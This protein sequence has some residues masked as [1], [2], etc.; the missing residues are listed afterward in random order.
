MRN[1]VALRGTTPERDTPGLADR[2]TGPWRLSITTCGTNPK[3]APTSR[4]ARSRPRRFGRRTSGG[5]L[6][7]ACVSDFWLGAASREPSDAAMCGRRELQRRHV[8][9]LLRRNPGLN[10]V[11]VRDA[12][13][14][15]ADDPAVLEWAAGQGR[16]VITHD[17][18]TLTKH[19]F[20]R[21]AAGHSMPGVFEV[22]SVAGIGQAIDDSSCSPN[23]A[24]RAS[25]GPTGGS[26]S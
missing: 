6:P 5:S 26:T 14:S 16:V 10:I 20:N 12:G 1:C 18:S 2:Q 9:G 11:R 22:R 13:L 8:R 4:N 21:L 3:S 15:G 25:G 17:V 19:A 23:A 7:R 24:T